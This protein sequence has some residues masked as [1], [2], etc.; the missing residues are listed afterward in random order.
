[1]QMGPP[2]GGD[3]FGWIVVIVGTAILLYSSFLAI[4]ATIRPGETDPDHPKN[5]ILQEDR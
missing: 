5:V 2:A 3:P 1:M 4:K